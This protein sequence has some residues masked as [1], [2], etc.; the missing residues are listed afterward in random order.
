RKLAAAEA[1]DMPSMSSVGPQN[2]LSKN[3]L[4]AGALDVLANSTLGDRLLETVS[5]DAVDA[6][7]AWKTV[8]FSLLDALATLYTAE[9]RPN[10]VV[11]FLSRK[12]Y[13]ASFVGSILRRED[14]AIRTTLHADPASL[15]PLY[16]YEAK[17]AFFLRLAQRQDGAERLLENGILDVLADCGFLD[18]KPSV[19][20]DVGAK[21]N[22][23][24]AF[25][26]ARS[27]RYH[28]LLMP[29]LDLVLS[30]VTRIG[31]DNLALWMKAARFV[32]QHYGVLESILKDVS[33]S[34]NPLSIAQLTEAK[35]ITSLVFY[36]SRQRAVLDRE[37][38]LASSG[39]VGV[40]S[41]HLTMLSLLPKF[42]TSSNWIKRLMPTNDVE[43]AQAQIPASSVAASTPSDG[44]DDSNG[45]DYLNAAKS[46]NAA[47]EIKRS[48][49]GHQASELVDSTI[50]NVLA[51]AQTV[52]ELPK[53]VLPLEAA[54]LFRPAFSWSIEHSR[55]SDYL[56]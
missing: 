15:N 9:A 41:L 11:Q 12:N 27:E 47:K 34:A 37:A 8:A 6:S 33:V 53:G 35:A 48:L 13:L 10:R 1:E 20:G 16:I 4:L 22:Y 30:L 36:I 24:D 46:D 39:Y 29:A 21:S 45:N 23:A 43:R 26:P 2:R 38:A 3:K 51:Y 55:E 5:S 28:Q 14:Q 52:T 18:L 40:S 19:G 49:F 7:D 31:R 25:I 32:S 42:S 44:N 54:R 17:M 56:P 50:Q